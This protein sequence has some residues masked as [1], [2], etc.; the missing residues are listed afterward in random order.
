MSLPWRRGLAA[1]ALLLCGPMAWST[2]AAAVPQAAIQPAPAGLHFGDRSQQVAPYG[3][4][5]REYWISGLARTYKAAATLRSD[6]R[7][8]A[9]VASSNVPY[10]TPMI[11][12]RPTDPARFNGIVILEWLNVSSGYIIDV[13]WSMA[14]EEFLREGYAYVGLTNQKVGLDG[15]K[16]AYPARYAAGNL[17]N[18]DISYDLLSQ[19]AR[20]IREQYGVLLGG[21]VP[22]KIIAT[23]H[24]QSALRLTTYVNAIHPLERVIDGFMIH[25]RGNTGIKLSANDLRGVPSSTVIRAD[26]QEPVFQIQSEMDVNAQPDTSKAVDTGRIRYWEVAGASHSDQYLLD[27]VYSISERDTGQQP[28]TCLK[29]AST[30]PFHR[31]QSAAYHHLVQWLRQGV[32]PPTAPRIKRNLLGNIQRDANGNALG[33]LRLPEIDVPVATYGINN[34]TV[35]S[36]EFLDLF[37]CTTSGSTERFSTLKLYALYP[38]HAAYVNQYKAAA[39]AAVAAGYLLPADRDRAVQQAGSAAIPY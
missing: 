12:R 38:S 25:G 1:A 34:F 20:A 23:G 29:P 10:Q 15:S 22:Q 3:Y 9:V 6:G 18:D 27:A 26:L 7:W 35:G 31:A 36:L 39:D 4:T 11:V 2:A 13:D 24:S 28:A 17:P 14:R 33:G 21:L 32:A 8:S 5:D 37:A 19:A 30:M 16:E